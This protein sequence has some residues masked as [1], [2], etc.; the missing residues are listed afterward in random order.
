MKVV[1]KDQ[2]KGLFAIV[3]IAEKK[4]PQVGELFLCPIHRKIIMVY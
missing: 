1:G 3:I 2:S 4:E